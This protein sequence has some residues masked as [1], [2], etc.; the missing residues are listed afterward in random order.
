VS[1]VLMSMFVICLV[2]LHMTFT[3]KLIVLDDQHGAGD[4][5][6]SLHQV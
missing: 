1:L 6:I 5:F 2:D 4:A 3:M